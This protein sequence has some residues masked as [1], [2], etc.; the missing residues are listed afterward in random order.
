MAA[1]TSSEITLSQFALGVSR[2]APVLSVMVSRMIGSQWM[3]P[4]ANVA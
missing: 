4:E 2:F 3:P 1:A